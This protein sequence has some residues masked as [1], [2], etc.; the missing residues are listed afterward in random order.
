VVVVALGA[1]IGIGVWIAPTSPAAT[2]RSLMQSTIAAAISAGTYHYVERST[3][4]GLP[5]DIVGTAAPDSGS[6]V[7]TER[8][9]S[10]TDVFDLRLLHGVVY[11]RGNEAAVVDQLGVPV[12]RAP[13][14]TRHWVSVRRGEAVYQGFEEGITTKSNIDQLTSV[15]VPQSTSPLSGTA[16]PQTQIVGGVIVGKSRV[17][18]G[19]ATL[20]VSNSTSLP[21]SL[22]GRASDQST[23]ASISLS[24]SFSHWR[25]RV[26]V[27]APSNPIPYSSLDATPR[28]SSGG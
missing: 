14:V 22:T 25:E 17:T 15:M 19:V 12:A 3:T 4:D 9:S 16:V 26:R 10:G 1:G 28:S 13:G 11:F 5:D 2:A 8:G 21:T 23:G 27:K 7:I 18:S 24:W 6:Q 20:N